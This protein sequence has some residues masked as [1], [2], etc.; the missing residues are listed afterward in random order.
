MK[1]MFA[2]P[3]SLDTLTVMLFGSLQNQSDC[4]QPSPTKQTNKQQ[5]KNKKSRV[6]GRALQ[7]SSHHGERSPDICT[8]PIPFKICHLRRECLDGKFGPLSDGFFHQPHVSV[9]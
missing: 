8:N 6:K 2:A 4:K 3:P 1:L 5:T 7:G 9:R